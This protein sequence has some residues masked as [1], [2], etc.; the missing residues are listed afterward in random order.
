MKE[1]IYTDK[2]PAPIGPYSQACMVGNML[3]C[4]GQIAINPQ[5]GEFVNGSIEEQT[6][7][8][9]ENIREI[10]AKAGLTYENV[11]KTTCF[12]A[13]MSDFVSF[14]KVYG[15]YF[16]SSPARSCVAV[17]E[18]PKSALVEIEVIATKEN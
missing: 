1:F 18:L 13:N 15:E 4:S 11:V 12:L 17:K 3:Y 6:R 2:A 5:T 9:C 14:N 7:L 16:I 8:C 10:L